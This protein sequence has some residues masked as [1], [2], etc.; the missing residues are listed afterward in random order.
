[1]EGSDSVVSNMA[2]RTDAASRFPSAS[3]MDNAMTD[4]V[5]ESNEIPPAVRVLF[6]CTGNSCRSQMAEGLL[7]ELGGT[8]FVALSAGAK[9]AG[10][11]HERA[12]AAM[13]EIGIDISGQRSKSILEF[14]P[15]NG[16]P[17]DVIISVCS[18]AEKEC[19]HFPGQ[20]QR[21]HWP[22]DDPYHSRGTEDEV[23]AEFRRV[24]DE[25]RQAL[26]ERLIDRAS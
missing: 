21:L 8:R 14:L 5:V 13:K 2:V 1:M 6:L 4:P 7:R 11:V 17:P 12:V 10:Y 20:V 25:I 22:F 18:S 24:R 3:A 19:P 9:P 16:E 26:Q 23:M 15:P